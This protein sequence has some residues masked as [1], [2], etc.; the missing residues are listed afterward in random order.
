MFL[1]II[2]NAFVILAATLGGFC[3]SNFRFGGTI[4]PI[5]DHPLMA[6]SFGDDNCY[7]RV[8]RMAGMERLAAITRIGNKSAFDT[9]QSFQ[10]FQTRKCAAVRST[11]RLVSQ[12]VVR[13]K[14]QIGTGR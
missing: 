6:D 11:S 12:A 10:D 5:P 1:T 9:L 7:I 4:S 14:I 13:L 2:E 8:Y 3:N